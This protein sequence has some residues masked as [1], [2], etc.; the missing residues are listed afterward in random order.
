[1]MQNSRHP[2]KWKLCIRSVFQYFNCNMSQQVRLV[3]FVYTFQGDNVHLLVSMP[4]DWNAVLKKLYG[5]SASFMLVCLLNTPGLTTKC[6]EQQN[7]IHCSPSFIKKVQPGISNHSFKQDD[8]DRNLSVLG[9]VCQYIVCIL[10]I[11]HKD[12]NKLL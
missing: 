5:T 2:L 7:A 10:I 8:L 9:L 4:K 12:L 11:M 6:L 1:M 3:T